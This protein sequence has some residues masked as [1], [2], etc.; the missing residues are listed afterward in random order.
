MTVFL[1]LNKTLPKLSFSASRVELTLMQT[2]PAVVGA[3]EQSGAHD[4]E[5]RVDEVLIE[6]G[7][8]EEKSK[9]KI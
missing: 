5:Y 7:V 4:I 3:R 1:L 8:L 9:I 6:R 2:M